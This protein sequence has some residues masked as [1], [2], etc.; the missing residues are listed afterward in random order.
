MD[1]NT[2]RVRDKRPDDD[3]PD[4]ER[5]PVITWQMRTN[6]KLFDPH[7]EAAELVKKRRLYNAAD[8][9]EDQ[10]LFPDEAE[11]GINSKIFIR[12]QNALTKLETGRMPM[13]Q[14][15]E[16]DMDEDYED[17]LL[18]DDVEESEWETDEEDRMKRLGADARGC[19]RRREM[20]GIHD[21]LEGDG[22]GYRPWISAICIRL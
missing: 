7:P 19:M 21:A 8:A 9:K 11:G 16:A 17:I 3:F 20:F 15:M 10:I 13:E 6:P 5:Q 14:F 12:V 2:H 4:L 22:H 1:P 18:A